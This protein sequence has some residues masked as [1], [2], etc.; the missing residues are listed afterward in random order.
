MLSLSTANPF[1][2]RETYDK[3]SVATY[4]ALTI[5]TWLLVVALCLAYTIKDPAGA[6][7]IQDQNATH[8]SPFAL[9]PVITGIYWLLLLVLQIVYICFLFGTTAELVSAAASVGSHFIVNNL[10]VSSFILLWVHAHFWW[11]EVVLVFNFFN[12]TSLYFRHLR[13][14]F[15]VHIPVVSGP[16]V[17]NFMALFT[18]G[19]V[20][21]N[22]QS[23]VTRLFANIA[24]WVIMLYGLLFLAA[25]QDYAIG[26]E[27][28]LLV[29]ALAV[30]Q[31]IIK[32]I[33]LQF[34]FAFIILGVLVL[35]T[36]L[37]VVPAFFGKELRFAKYEYEEEAIGESRLLLEDE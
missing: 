19:A 17:W 6:R 15:F 37:I 31:L 11:A 13:A 34:I 14:P 8:P 23:L 27:M 21:V 32:V 7:T 25:F 26:I 16:L 33:P 24:I 4:R 18:D 22:A 36:L 30:Q 28:A 3:R 9:H 29:A 10:L 2:R 12:L 20:T 1:A 5:V 35:A